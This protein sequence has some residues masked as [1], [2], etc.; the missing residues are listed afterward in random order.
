MEVEL[1]CPYCGELLT[2]LVDESGGRTQS[3]VEDCQ[4]CCAPIQVRAHVDPDNVDL[5]ISRLDE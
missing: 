3:Y 2:F 4:V 5:E 1:S